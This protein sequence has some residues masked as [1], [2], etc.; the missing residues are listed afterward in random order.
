MYF[1]ARCAFDGNL[2][3]GYTTDGIFRIGELL[4]HGSSVKYACDVSYTLVGS[5]VRHCDDGSWDTS[6][7]SCK[8][9]LIGDMIKWFL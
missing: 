6:L 1:I 2:D 5:I 8:G 7:P 3:K 9:K 4:R